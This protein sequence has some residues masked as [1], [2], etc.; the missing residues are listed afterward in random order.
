V[1]GEEGADMSDPYVS[2]RG[3]I[4][5][6]GRKAQTEGESALMRRRHGTHRPTWPAREAAAREGEWA[7]MST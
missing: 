6:H 1:G 4:R 5:L 3:E 7:G 2:D